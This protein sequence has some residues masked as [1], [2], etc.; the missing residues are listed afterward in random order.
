MFS[1]YVMFKI[2][3][4]FV[5][6]GDIF[7]VSGYEVYDCLLELMREM[8]K[9]LIVIYDVKFFLDEVR[10][11]GNLLRECERGLLLNKGVELVVVY[12]VIRMNCE[13]LYFCLCILL[14]VKLIFMVIVVIGWNL[15]YV[16]KGFIKCINGVIKD[17]L[18][19]F[20]KYFFNMVI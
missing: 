10:N 9:K 2:Y 8:F 3:I 19:I 4:F 15:V 20:F 16:N 11:L 17:E 6:G 13:F 7:W 1:D 5:I 14:C 12:F 18:D